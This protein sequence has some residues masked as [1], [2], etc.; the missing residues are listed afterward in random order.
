MKRHT[1]VRIAEETVAVVQ[2]G[3]Y[4][5]PNGRIVDISA[6][7]TPVLREQLSTRRVNS[8][9]SAIRFG[10]SQRRTLSPPSNCETNPRYKASRECPR[11]PAFR[12][13][14]SILHRRE[15]PAADFLA[16]QGSGGVAR[17]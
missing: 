1:R 3:E 8:S 11:K 12:L 4:E 2:K 7:S 14:L 6:R 17:A 13:L 16:E 9:G 10:P 5:S 15:I